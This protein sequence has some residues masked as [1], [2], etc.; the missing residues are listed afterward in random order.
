MERMMGIE[1][2]AT[3]LASSCST[4][5]LHPRIGG[6]C[7]DSNPQPPACKAGAL[8]LELTARENLENGRGLA[9]LSLSTWRRLLLRDLWS[10]RAACD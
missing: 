5:E 10:R 6:P 2:T 4:S 3:S 1:P 9:I 8:P 7:E